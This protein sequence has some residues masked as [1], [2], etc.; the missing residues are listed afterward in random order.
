MCFYPC[1]GPCAKRSIGSHLGRYNGWVFLVAISK[2][3]SNQFILIPHPLLKVLAFLWTEMW[4]LTKCKM[5]SLLAWSFSQSYSFL[6]QGA[7]PHE[8]LANASF[9]LFWNILGK[10]ISPMVH[11]L[12]SIIKTSLG[13]NCSFNIPLFGNWIQYTYIYQSFDKRYN[14]WLASTLSEACEKQELPLNLCVI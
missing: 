9:E 14:Q 12:W 7:P 8:P 2:H 13:R 5:K 6:H 1:R 10:H 4:F 11:M 3:F